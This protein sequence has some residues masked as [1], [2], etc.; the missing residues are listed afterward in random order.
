MNLLLKIQK[1]LN[2]IG[3]DLKFTINKTSNF[4]DIS[5]ILNKNI[6]YIDLIDF[7]KD[8]SSDY[9]IENNYLN[10]YISRDVWL[11]NLKF[12]K[13][14]NITNSAFLS[15]FY[16]DKNLAYKI[17]HIY[18][19]LYFNSNIVNTESEAD[20]II[21][22]RQVKKINNKTYKIYNI[23]SGDV[24]YEA[25][26]YSIFATKNNTT[27]YLDFN[28]LKDISFDNKLFVLYYALERA[29]YFKKNK[30]Q[31]DMLSAADTYLFK[32]LAYYPV[33]KNYSISNFDF[34][35]LLKHLYN[36]A[37][38][39]NKIT[40]SYAKYNNLA[41]NVMVDVLKNELK[42]FKIIG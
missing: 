8:F 16:Q 35:Y 10:F 39:F 24:D 14:E 17:K 28:N 25:M 36:I 21:S 6:D 15:I 18:Q 30:S 41:A 13:F 12:I 23:C 29:L 26:I 19:K 34:Y 38:L 1:S 7:A 2:L 32:L 3:E 42:F 11:D 4:G 5:I 20:I 31:T 22:N 40:H 37:K 33:I 27:T 9:K